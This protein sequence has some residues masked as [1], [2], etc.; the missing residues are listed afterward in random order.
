[1]CEDKVSG[2]GTILAA[3]SQTLLS[4]LSTRFVFMKY[5]LADNVPGKFYPPANET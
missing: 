3:N 1:M 2:S 5:P 4:T